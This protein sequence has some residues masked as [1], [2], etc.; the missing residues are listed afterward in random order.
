MR[1]VVSKLLLVNNNIVVFFRVKKDK[2]SIEMMPENTLALIFNSLKENEAG[3]YTCTGVYT[4]TQPVAKS[5]QIQTIGKYFQ[6]SK[7]HTKQDI[8]III[9]SY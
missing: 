1:L 7:S 3:T 4:N 2:M 8:E 5:V 9:V 6:N